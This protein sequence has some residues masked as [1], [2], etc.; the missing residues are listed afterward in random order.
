MICLLSVLI[1]LWVEKP[2]CG[3]NISNHRK[4]RRRGL[5]KVKLVPLSNLLLTISGGTCVMVP[6]WYTLC[7]CDH[8]LGK[9]LFIRFA[10]SVFYAPSSICVCASTRFFLRMEC[11]IG[12]Y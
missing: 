10:V 4:N 2:S 7:P 3:P 1:H 11:S 8:L 9:E 6:E 12:L 5:N